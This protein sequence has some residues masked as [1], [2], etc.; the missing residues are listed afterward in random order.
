MAEK[1]LAKKRN[2]GRAEAR[3]TGLR[4]H[5]RDAAV[6]LCLSVLTLGAFSGV[7]AL[8]AV[9]P[10]HVESVAWVAERKDVLSTFLGLL[11]LLAYGW[12]ARAPGW[13]KYVL[14]AAAFELS[15][16]AKP[17]LMTLPVLL[18]LF[19]YWPLG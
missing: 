14:V 16:L 2:A 6:V 9:H 17:M 13:L 8:F 4:R 11:A 10:Q 12:Y 15:L 1:T 18:L 3:A 5:F 7:T 19:D